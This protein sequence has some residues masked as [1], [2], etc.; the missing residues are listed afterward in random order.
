MTPE[1]I[2]RVRELNDAFRTHPLGI[3]GRIMLSCGVSA[4]G[5]GFINK[6]LSAVRE[7]SDFN[8]DNDPHKEHDAAMFELDGVVC[9]W[10]IDYYAADMMHGSEEPWDAAQTK[11]V[12][13]IMEM[14]ER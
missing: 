8:E 14:M 1:Q 11:R 3:G 5:D 13:T 12:L 10:K 2:N 4:R 7:F 9:Y 6:A